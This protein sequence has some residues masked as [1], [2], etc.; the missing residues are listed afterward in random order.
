MRAT[1]TSYT[2]P[3]RELE[4]GPVLGLRATGLFG[5]IKQKAADGKFKLASR[6]DEPVE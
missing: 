2:N 6:G 4:V 1:E 5:G 3:E